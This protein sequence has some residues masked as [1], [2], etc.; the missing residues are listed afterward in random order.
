MYNIFVVEDH[1]IFR[2]GIETLLEEIKD[3]R[4]AGS[5]NSGESFLEK[6]QGR[7]IDVVFMDIKMPGM[8][9]IEATKKALEIRPELKII[10]L[11]MF[12]EER[13]LQQMLRAGASGFLLKN[14]TMSDI[15][16]AIHAVMSG[17]RYFSEELMTL[18][19][20]MHVGKTPVSSDKISLSEKERQVLRIISEGEVNVDFG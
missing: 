17:Y 19:W 5:A 9:G 18:L 6:I 2:K 20:N 7:D 4:L 1:E 10:A 11:T 12:G 15:E 8:G 3:V 16:K 14:V 13:F